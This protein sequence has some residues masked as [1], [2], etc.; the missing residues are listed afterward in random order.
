MSNPQ[1][2]EPSS[3]ALELLM[4]YEQTRSFSERA[5]THLAFREGD[6]ELLTNTHLEDYGDILLPPF[7]VYMNALRQMKDENPQ[8]AA[9]GRQRYNAMTPG[10]R[11]LVSTV[12][13]L[14]GLDA[15]AD[16]KIPNKSFVDGRLVPLITGSSN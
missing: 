7:L 9:M 16:G 2:Y 8:V 4:E 1:M 11:R 6:I 10:I 12:N 5:M 3:K 14:H 13:H 15:I